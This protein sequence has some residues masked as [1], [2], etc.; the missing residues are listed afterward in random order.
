[1]VSGNI[2]AA[3]P[4][5]TAAW[6]RLLAVLHARIGYLSGFEHVD[7]VWTYEDASQ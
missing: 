3:L 2:R 5:K 1:V 7:V 6:L 4:A